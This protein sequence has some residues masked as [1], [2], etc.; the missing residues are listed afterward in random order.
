MNNILDYSDNYCTGCS[1]CT[2]ICPTNAIDYVLSKEG[3]YEAV[4]DKEK[5]I[6]CGKCK[7]VCIK[8]EENKGK[9]INEGTLY[10]AQSTN[11]DTV[12]SCTSG[13]IA[14]EISKYGIE[15]EYKI[16]GVVF[17]Y[18]QNIAKTVIVDNMEDLELL[19][20][21]K[22]LQSN[23]KEAFSD[24]IKYCE[25]NE[26]EKF[27]VFG[28]PCQIT[29]LYK[30]I[31]EK[32]I[33]NE[34]VMVD[35]FCHGVPSYLVW[36]GYMKWLSDKKGIDKIDK[37]TFRSKH[38]EWHEFCIEI[39][40]RNGIYYGTRRKDLFFKAFFDDILFNKACFKCDMRK[41]VS[42]A[43][44]RLGD[45]WGK[46]YISNQ[47]GVSAVL[48]LSTKGD[49]L[50]DALYKHKK[51]NILDKVDNLECFKSQSTQNYQY[52]DIQDEYIKKAVSNDLLEIIKE[53]RKELP[54]KIRIK[55]KLKES[56]YFL[57]VKCRMKIKNI[58]YRFK[59]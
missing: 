33:K 54:I 14:Y 5:C 12:L 10:S 44:I 46:R 43:D 15:N 29:G 34:F 49:K 26:E 24:I 32:R 36:N 8:F 57:P 28:T 13:G 55:K 30:L 23:S 19:K 7:K 56:I 2:E 20:G 38:I 3:F 39:E 40:S 31:N 1:V 35:L 58:I 22:Y 17:D 21:S 37:V 47:E 11:K 45:L 6:M 50:I 42:Y 52:M 53:Y 18:N 51:I 59:Y 25:E 41:K 9:N 16:V 27:I 48:S 4:I